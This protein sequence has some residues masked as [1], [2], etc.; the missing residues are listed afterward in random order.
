MIDMPVRKH[1]SEKVSAASQA[2]DGGM[3]GTVIGVAIQRQ[4]QIEEKSRSL[5][6]ELDA[7]PPDFLGPAVD[8]DAHCR[9][10]LQ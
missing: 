4:A 1:Q 2:L 8:A 9:S 10:Q 5:G 3:G 6:F 7:R